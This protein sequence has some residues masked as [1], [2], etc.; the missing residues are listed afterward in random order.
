MYY[1]KYRPKKFS[2]VIGQEIIIKI[3]KNTIKRGEILHGYLF[4][5]ERGTG[6]TTVARI[7]AKTIN[8]LQPLDGE[9]C[10]HCVICDL[11]NKNKFLDMIEIDAASHRKIDDIRNLQEHI[12][13]RPLQGRYKVFI[14]D[15]AHML[16]DEAFNALLKTLE[17]PPKHVVFILATTEPSKIPPTILSRLQRLDFKRISY[18]QIVE[19]LKLILENEKIPF[20][21]SAL[22][23]IAEESEGSLRDAETLLEKVV[24]S[25]NPHLKLTQDYV[26][27]FLGQISTKQLLDFINLILEKKIE[28][29][30]SFLHEIYKNGFEL[31]S[32]L[33][34]LIKV[35]KEIIF[36]KIHPDFSKHL[37]NEKP[38]EIVDYMIEISKKSDV[39]SFKKL[40]RLF[41][42][43]D[44]LMRKEPPHPLLPIELAVLEF[45]TLE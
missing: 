9:A 3:L 7:F 40:L 35:I 42:E 45:I 34:G 32:F 39:N 29:A 15:E 24:L 13:F 37:I 31:L 27:N 41:F 22:Y 18:P 8:C 4:A 20:D 33:R 16:T 30:L 19:K 28:S 21:E 26:A 25:L 11:W 12:G 17:E 6:K 38:K 2:E 1:Q 5:G 44:S 10:D 14:I 23:L 43:A 36:I